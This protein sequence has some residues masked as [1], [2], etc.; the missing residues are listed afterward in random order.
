MSGG[1]E[2]VKTGIREMGET[3]RDEPAGADGAGPLENPPPCTVCRAV[4]GSPGDNLRTVLD[5]AGGAA[6]IVGSEDVVV[7]K[8][9]AQWWNHGGASLAALEALVEAVVERPGGFRGDVVIAENCHRGKAPWTRP[10]TGWAGR[11]LW[12]SDLPG[13]EN[14]NGLCRRLKERYGE[15]F[16]AVH[17]INVDAGGRR[18]RSPGEGEGYVYC[19]GTGGVPLLEC[20]N[21]RSGKGGRRTVMTYPVFRTDSGKMVDFRNGVWEEGGYSG[22]PLRFFNVAALNHHGLYC[23]PTSAVKNFLGITDLSGGADPFQGGKI[24]EGHFN[25]HAF[26]FDGHVSGPVRGML[27]RAVGT[28]MKTVRRADLNITTAEWTG[29]ISREFPPLAHTRA[30]LACRDPVALD[31]HA[32]RYVLYP[33]SRIGLHDPDDPTGPFY[34]DLAE[35]AAAAGLVGDEKDVPVVTAGPEGRGRGGTLEILGKKRWG[36]NRKM[37]VR[38]FRTRY[39]R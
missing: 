30:V 19:D 18:V 13:I 27:G 8:P 33:N 24:T 29:L 1:C 4:G 12:N 17:W 26:A 20:G 22:R 14:L 36:R 2:S 34:H 23:G 31:R 7:I 37:L 3:G 5:M 28:F 15:R 25:F 32:A 6:S 21:G 39:F 11:Y 38:Y 35:C 9:N 16:S 10:R